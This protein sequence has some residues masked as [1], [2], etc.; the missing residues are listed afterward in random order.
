MQRCA[1]GRRGREAQWE[2]VEADVPGARSSNLGNKADSGGGWSRLGWACQGASSTRKFVTAVRLAGPG[3]TLG[4][5]TARPGGLSQRA[6]APSCAPLPREPARPPVGRCEFLHRIAFFA[7]R[8]PPASPAQQRLRD[9]T[10]PSA[11][12]PSSDVES[13]RPGI[14]HMLLRPS[15]RPLAAACRRLV[16][17]CPEP[18]SRASPLANSQARRHACSL[19]TGVEEV[20]VKCRSNG[21]ITLK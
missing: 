12:S 21:S 3:R 20:T 19:S 7:R 10:R 1:E 9:A 13:V 4:A 6:C 17:S 2:R 15:P 16:L 8:Q 11:A 18:C 5:V 14:E